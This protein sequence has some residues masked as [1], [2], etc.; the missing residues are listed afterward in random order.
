M[1]LFVSLELPP[2]VR[3]HLAAELAGSRTTDVAQ[4]HITLAF[5]G[6]WDDPTTLVPG[7]AEVATAAAPLT[8]RLHGG[9]AFPGALWAG[10]AGDVAGLRRL[11]TGV[12][13]A[14]RAAGVQLEDRPF[15]PHVTVA[16]RVRDPRRLA[17]YEGPAWTATQVELVRSHLGATARHEVLERFPLG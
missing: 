13:A 5:V 7:L 6:E 14:C 17:D 2:E 1:R 11:A 4:W 15:R 10:V 8:L 12:G 3:T 16:R 9:G